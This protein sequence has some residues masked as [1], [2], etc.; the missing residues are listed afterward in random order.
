[1]VVE[2]NVTAGPFQGCRQSDA[3]SSHLTDERMRKMLRVWSP[4]L[5]P[6]ENSHVMNSVGL[7]LVC[8]WATPRH[9]RCLRVVG[10]KS[11]LAL[12]KWTCAVRAMKLRAVAAGSEGAHDGGDGGVAGV[13]RL[14]STVHMMV[15]RAELPGSAGWLRRCT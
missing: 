1:M 12:S 8:P 11:R 15:G 9:M 5:K 2:Q 7:M 13:G 10:R 6:L 14:A 4:K 3:D